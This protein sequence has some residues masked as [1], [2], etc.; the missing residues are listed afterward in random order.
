M[1]HKRFRKEI[2]C[3]C[4]FFTTLEHTTV[5]TRCKIGRRQ[6]I[7]GDRGEVGA[8][9]EHIIETTQLERRDAIEQLLSLQRD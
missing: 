1:T 3:P 6:E 2:G 9:R 8:S 5:A 7:R 4:Q